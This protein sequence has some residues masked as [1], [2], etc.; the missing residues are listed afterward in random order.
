MFVKIRA[1]SEQPALLAKLKALLQQHPGPLATVLFYEQ[2]Q[3]VLALSDAYRIKPSRELFAEMEDM[4]GQ[5]T[6]RVK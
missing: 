5:D 3:K 1:E 6:V 2:G 4:L